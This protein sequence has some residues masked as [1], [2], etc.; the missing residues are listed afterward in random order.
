MGNGGLWWV[1]DSSLLVHPLKTLSL[2]QHGLRS[3][4]NCSSRGLLHRLQ[5]LQD[6]PNQALVPHRSQFLSRETCYSIVSPRAVMP[7][8]N[9]H[10]HIYLHGL[11][12]GHLLHGGLLRGLWE[13]LCFRTFHLLLKHVL[14]PSFFS[15]LSVC[16]VVVSHTVLPHVHCHVAFCPPNTLSQR[17]HQGGCWTQPCPAAG[18]LEPAGTGCVLQGSPQRG[19]L[20]PLL[21]KPCR[22]NP[23]HCIQVQCSVFGTPQLTSVFKT[24]PNERGVT[25]GRLSARRGYL[26]F[27]VP[28]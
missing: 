6:K 27:R 12:C 21:P 3:F 22:V 26:G 28:P 1:H 9:I 4:R 2:F 17:W 5:V 19:P 25:P 18:P 8:G 13:N 7:S 14:V 10:L 11:Q 15:E 24:A 20:Q 16:R 23:K